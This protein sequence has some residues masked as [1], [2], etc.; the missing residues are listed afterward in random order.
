[1]RLVRFNEG[2]IG[3]LRGDMVHD[4]TAAIGLDPAA[5]PP[6]GMIQLIRDF[7]S[8]RGKLEQAAGGPGM[9]L[10]SVRLLAPI[11]WPHNLFAYPVNYIAH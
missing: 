10:A 9:P 4:A 3:I 6:V 11:V 8:L 1:V 7:A 5:W 2:R